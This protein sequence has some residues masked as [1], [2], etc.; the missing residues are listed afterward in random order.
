MALFTE[1]AIRQ[2]ARAE[3][4]KTPY[5][6]SA[7]SIILESVKTFST[8]KKYD[9]FLSHSIRDAELILGMKATL[10]DMGYSVYVDWIEDPQLDRSRVTPTTADKLRTRMNSSNS[11]FYVTTHNSTSSKWMPWECGYFDGKKEKAAIVPI[12]SSS[13]GN[14]YHGQ[15]YLGLYPFVVKDKSRIGKELLYIHKSTNIYTTYDHWVKT[16][17]AQIQWMES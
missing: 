11:L 13:T 5:K 16:P 17:N 4:Q 1:S 8:A 12:V 7:E 9:I 2:R 15:E 6:L 14:T 3:V 10:E